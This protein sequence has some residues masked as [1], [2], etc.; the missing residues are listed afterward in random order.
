MPE[1]PEVETI[2]GQLAR[3]VVGK[4]V[5]S[6]QALWPKSLIGRGVNIEAL[7]GRRITAVTRRGKVVII[8][9]DGGVSILVHLRMT[10]QLLYE[11]G[12]RVQSRMT[13]ALVN[14]E[15]ATRLVFNDQRKFGSMTVVPTSAVGSDPLL[16]RMGPE[17]LGADFDAVVLRA[18]LARH[19]R[20]AIKATLLDQATVAGIG[21]IYAD[22]I[23]FS[24]GIHPETRSGD[25]NDGQVVQLAQSIIAILA[26][27]IA[28]GG[29]TMRDYVDVGGAAG[30]YLDQARVFGRTGLACV[31]CGGP[32]V[33][34]RVAGRGTHLCPIC[35]VAP[36]ST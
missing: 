12:A 22:E 36:S 32:I 29:A 15:D 34:T 5:A 13:R 26:E 31:A 10:G 25:L 18:A 21:N 14:F 20:Q 19:P 33:K 7:I 11:E 23:L 9:L 1:L 28:T 35:Q 24:S 30:K 16:S 4:K 2:T 3:L 17:P 8:T 27:G 6:V